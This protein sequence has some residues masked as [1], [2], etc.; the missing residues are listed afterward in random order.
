[1]VAIVERGSQ[2]RQRGRLQV[3]P[4][5]AKEPSR[6]RELL[7]PARPP[8]RAADAARVPPM[9]RGPPARREC[10]RRGA[11]ASPAASA[12]RGVP[13]EDQPIL[14]RCTMCSLHEAGGA[15]R[16]VSTRSRDPAPQ[17]ATCRKAAGDD[18]LEQLAVCST[19]CGKQQ[20]VGNRGSSSSG[21]PSGLTTGTSD[22][23]MY[24]IPPHTSS[25]GAVASA[26]MA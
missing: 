21:C 3:R 16:P 25:P 26:P 8:A 11:S 19:T 4:S 5:R 7:P 23:R 13:P 24:G 15:E 9:W 18:P 22:W 14:A 6:Q 12:A 2:A 1:M 17:V 10:R 20:P